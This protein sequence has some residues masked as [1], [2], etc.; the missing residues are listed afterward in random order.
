MGWEET[1]AVTQA[2]LCTFWNLERLTLVLT[3][4]STHNSFSSFGPNMP[5]AGETLTT[6]EADCLPTS[7]QTRIRRNQEGPQ[8][9]GRAPTCSQFRF[10]VQVQPPVKGSWERDNMNYGSREDQECHWK[11]ILLDQWMCWPWK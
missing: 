11:N 6:Q 3:V 4:N 2:S 9:S 5:L 1:I 10:P 7:C 8:L